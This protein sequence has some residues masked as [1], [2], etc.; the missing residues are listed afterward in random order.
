MMILF[1]LQ[2]KKVF[3]QRLKIIIFFG[4]I[5]EKRKVYFP[6]CL[7][8]YFNVDQDANNLHMKR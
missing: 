6:R 5:G 3:Y 8:S 7:H 2:L 4:Y 1:Y